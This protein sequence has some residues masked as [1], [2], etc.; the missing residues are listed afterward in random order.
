M[1]YLKKL[2]GFKILNYLPQKSI[3]QLHFTAL[4]KDAKSIHLH[5]E[6]YVDRKI[7]ALKKM[8]AMLN[9]AESTNVCRNLLLLQY[10]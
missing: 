3:P 10:F 8:E 1:N 6:V 5:N 4:R 7:Q 9:Y 2:D